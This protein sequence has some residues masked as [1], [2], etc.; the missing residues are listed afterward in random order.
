M[1]KK[2]L[3]NSRAIKLSLGQQGKREEASKGGNETGWRKRRTVKKRSGKRSRRR[4]KVA[5]RKVEGAEK[6]D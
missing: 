5:K 4:R 3:H 2:K 1:T 6:K